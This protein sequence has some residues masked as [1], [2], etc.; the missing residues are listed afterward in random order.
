MLIKSYAKFSKDNPQI[1][2]KLIII[3]RGKLTS[4][5]KILARQLMI[6]EKII[7]VPY[8]KQ[9][10]LYYQLF[11]VFCLTSEYEGFGLVLL[12][13]LSFGLPVVATKSGSIPE[14]IKNKKNGYL[15]M[16][17]D[18]NK[19]SQRIKDCLD[20]SEL[21]NFKKKQINFIKKN[22]LLDKV[23]LKTEKIYKLHIN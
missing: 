11:D 12:E 20:L 8:A 2:S 19:F 23:F 9:I 21:I 17:N 13:A 15:V 14:I 22:F 7:W 16:Q 1:T 18:I 10:N 6:S 3:G 4:N 5:L